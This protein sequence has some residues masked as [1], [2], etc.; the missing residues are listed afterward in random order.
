[1]EN[2]IAV[3][4]AASSRDR[5]RLGVFWAATIGYGLFYVCRLSLNVLKKSIV[6]ADYLSETQLG[7]IGSALF[8]SY[9]VGKFVNGFLADRVNVRLFMSLGLIVA[10]AVNLILGFK[11][12]F[13]LF[14][15]LWGVNGWFQSIGAPC[16][17]IALRRWYSEKGLGT[18]YGYWSASH[19]IG[20]A[21]TFIITAFVVSALGWQW[22]FFSAAG[23]GFMGVVM[24]FF[25]LKPYPSGYVKQRAEVVPPKVRNKEISKKQLEVLKNPMIWFLAL[26][27]AFMYIARYAVNSWGI[28]Y[29]EAEKGYSL[30]EASTLIS[31]SSV[32]GIIGTVFSGLISDKFFKG[33]RTIPASL[34]SALNLLALLMFLFGPAHNYTFDIISMILFGIS[35]GVLICFLGGLMAV[36]LAPKEA[37]GAALGVIGV[38]S[39]MGAGLQDIVS[40]WLFESK[41]SLDAAGVMQYDFSSIRIFWIS[42]AAI[43]FGF[44][45]LILFL[46]RK[47]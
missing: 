31:V 19:N 2:T 22:G 25:L 16:C 15:I 30:V 9:A 32:C 36:D 47:K 23:L 24:I 29:F 42:A 44:L 43:S 33:N 1:M 13:I 28:Y 45:L 20:E 3:E 17:V 18:V 11:L 7:I 14:I 41:K 40:G 37:A 39:Y 12:P 5:A 34:M 26:G 35:I 8:F 4:T 10:A 46:N 38:A 27:S 21:M 6:D